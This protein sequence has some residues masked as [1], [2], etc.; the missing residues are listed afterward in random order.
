M[1]EFTKILQSAEKGDPD[2]AEKLLDEVYDELR[3]LAAARMAKEAPGQTLQPTALVHEAWMRLNGGSGQQWS[4][5]RHFFGAA[6]ESMRRIL[7][8]NARRKCRLR[9][10]GR[11]ERIPITEV[12]VAVNDPSEMVV[13]VHEAID[14]LA[15]VDPE[16]AEIVNLRYFVGLKNTEIEDPLDV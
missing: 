14:Q 12:T 9:R 11:Q 2:A 13:E 15:E 1:N 16:K 6:A 5:R 8:E 10:G 4:N 7:I 3:R